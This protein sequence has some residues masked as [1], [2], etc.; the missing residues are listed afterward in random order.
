MQNPKEIRQL[1]KL[2]LEEATILCN[3]GKY[4]GAFYLAGY[5]IEL[6]LKAKICERLG[7]P[8]LLE[9]NSSDGA[10]KDIKKTVQTHDLFVLL[11][12]SGL[13]VPFDISKSTDKQLLKASCLIERKEM[14]KKEKKSSGRKNYVIFLT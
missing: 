8:N 1:A 9:D 7:I 6:M 3:H 13:K 4:E 14:P 10:V 5:A 12:L 11:V 2:R